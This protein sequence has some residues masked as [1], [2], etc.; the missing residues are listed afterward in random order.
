MRLHRL[1]VTA[2]GPFAGTESVDFDRLTGDGLFLLHGPTGAG[3]TS[4]LDAVAYALYG[5][6]PGQRERGSLR[7][8]HAAPDRLTEVTLEA[9]LAGRRLRLTRS[10][11]QERPRRRGGG[12]TT[13]KART[14][15][16]EWRDGTWHGLSRSHQE[17]GQEVERLLGMSMDQ[18]CQVVLLPQGEFARFLRADTRE[19]ADLLKRLFSTRTFEDVELWLAER[20]RQADQRVEQA[21]GGVRGLAQ[22]LG[23]AA[24]GLPVAEL[25][26]AAAA[27]S[28]DEPPAPGEAAGTG[29]APG[30]DAVERLGDH[31]RLVWAALLLAE[32][33]ERAELTEVL[34]EGAARQRDAARERLAGAERLAE[35]RRRHDRAREVLAELA[36]SAEQRREDAAAVAAA[37]RAAPV[38]RL[39]RAEEEAHRRAGLAAAA[40]RERRAAL[41]ESLAARTE[42]QLA[43]EAARLRQEAGALRHALDEE[44][45]L[46]ELAGRLAEL[47]A[48]RAAA[49]RAAAEAEAVLA[50]LP[51]RR[52]AVVTELDAARETAASAS[53]LAAEAARATAAVAA[54]VRRDELAGLLEVAR[55]RERAARDAELAAREAWLGLRE[56]RLAGMAAELAAGLRQGEPCPVCGSAA[57]PAPASGAGPAARVTAEDEREAERRAARAREELAAAQA[58]LAELGRESA[59]AT[60]IAG[61]ESVAGHRAAQERLSARHRAA[62]RAGARATELAGRLAELDAEAERCARRREEA[63]RE[64][65]RLAERADAL[66]EQERRARALVAEARGGFPTVR[67]RLEALVTLA[68]AA[69]EAVR[70][71]GEAAAA[72]QAHLGAERQLEEALAEAGFAS[73]AAL[74][75]AEIGQQELDKRRRR[76]EEWREREVAARAQLEEPEVARAGA[77]PRPD[78]AGPQREVAEAESRLREATVAAG[79]AGT[80][81][82]QVAELCA[83]LRAETSAL[84]PLRARATVVRR[85]AELVA[86]T[87]DANARRMKL[88]T[89]VLAARLEQVAAAATVRLHRMSQGRYTLVHSDGRVARKR[90]WGL[91]LRVADAWTGVERDTATLSGGET[92]IVS[93]ALA[94]GLA[95]VVTEESGGMPLDT[96]FIDEGFGTLDEET[97]DE[98]LDVL[99]ALRERDRAVGIVSHVAELRQRVR[100]RLRAEKGREGSRLR[101]VAAEG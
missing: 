60:A 99:D 6:V 83:R 34:R 40:E 87:G 43:A 85:T 16:E 19:R 46:D 51:E 57:H 92:F 61:E 100:N 32:A 101:V 88:S 37:E 94:L 29:A 98:V 67:G 25:A 27:V 80:R 1:T 35:L 77:L 90:V 11:D 22:R 8:D 44:A 70:A 24:H 47:A 5:N 73:A 74:R 69:E 4:V 45:R 23:Q 3:K 55:E 12:T 97:L 21:L 79:A 72:E 59:A 76:L 86:G 64:R 62:E 2:F 89:Y 96:L 14:L 28:D 52:A 15:L 41:P 39:L 49:E 75:A 50:G 53:A 68:G 58:E 93:L 38:L 31:G 81:R 13:E 42:A 56:R 48:E 66:A 78:V 7:S 17:V 71:A 20:R 10:P 36:D 82:E 95:D 33:T 30:A 84:A 26:R 65:D 63:G 9:T 54:A 91:G 18:F